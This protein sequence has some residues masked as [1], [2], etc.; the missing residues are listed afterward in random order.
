MSH[1]VTGNPERKRQRSRAEG[2]RNRRPLLSEG[3][4]GSRGR[5]RY[6]LS[7][8]IR[9]AFSISFMFFGSPDG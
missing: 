1:A 9:A 4:D 2:G 3:R 5:S 6:F 7:L 8:P